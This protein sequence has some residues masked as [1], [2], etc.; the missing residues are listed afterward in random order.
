MKVEAC[1]PL[2][3]STHTRGERCYMVGKVLTIFKDE[4][5][6]EFV[7]LEDDNNGRLCICYADTAILLK[8]VIER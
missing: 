2:E 8:K 6:Q 5:G 7:V 3:N 1:K 4:A